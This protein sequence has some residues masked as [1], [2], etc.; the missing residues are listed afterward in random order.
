MA[1]FEYG[2]I[3]IVDFDPSVGHEYQKIRPAIIVQSNSSLKNSSL[4]TIVP[5]TSNPKNGIIIS[6]NSKNGLYK[7][8]AVK[9]NCITS[10]DKSRLLRKIGVA[11]KDVMKK[12]AEDLKL[13]LGL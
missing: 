8:S 11:Q 12:I 10:F 7:D 3:F 9:V 6:K 5:I 1:E 4:I 13:Y 2:D